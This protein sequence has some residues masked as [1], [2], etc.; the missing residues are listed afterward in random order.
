M[1]ADPLTVEQNGGIENDHEEEAQ[2]L[3]DACD[4]LGAVL[5]FRLHA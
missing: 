5:R 1:T 4:G 2:R 3:R